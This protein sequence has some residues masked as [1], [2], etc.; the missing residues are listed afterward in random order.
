MKSPPNDLTCN[1]LVAELD[2]I[3]L[4]GQVPKRKTLLVVDDEQ[5]V[6]ELMAQVLGQEGYNVLQADGAAEALC[7][8]TGATI[9]LLLTDFSMPE[10]DGLK[11]TR[12][13]RALCPNA[14]VLMVSGSLADMDGRADDLNYFGVLEKPFAIGELVSKVRGLLTEASSVP[15]GK[16]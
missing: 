11:L 7:I 12:R 1:T 9:H 13:F 4:H 3:P 10:T 6:R 5:E 14:P 8:A 15:S 16:D 2:A